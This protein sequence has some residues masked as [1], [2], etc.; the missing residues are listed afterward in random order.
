MVFVRFSV[1]KK[2]LN[3]TLKSIEWLSCLYICK[4]KKVIIPYNYNLYIL[5]SRYLFLRHKLYRSIVK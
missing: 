4:K 1:I 2:T 5:S 3:E